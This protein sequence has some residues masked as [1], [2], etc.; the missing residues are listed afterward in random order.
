[1]LATLHLPATAPR[2]LTAPEVAA[3]HVHF[4]PSQHLTVTDGAPAVR[5]LLG[6]AHD[7]EVMASGPAYLV[8]VVENAA[9][10]ELE[11]NTSATDEVV[12]LTGV[13]F[14]EEPLLGPVLVIE[15]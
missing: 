8:L 13:D 4:A 3:L 2:V 9:D 15:A 6:T 1:M 11:V 5:Q 10:L 14:D 7:F 12:R